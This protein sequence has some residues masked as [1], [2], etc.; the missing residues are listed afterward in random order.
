MLFNCGRGSEHLETLLLQEGVASFRPQATRFA[1]HTRDS[2]VLSALLERSGMAAPRTVYRLAV[3]QTVLEQ[4]V[5]WLGGF[6]LVVKQ[7]G[8]SLGAGVFLAESMPALRSLAEYLHAQ[9]QICILR[10]YIKPRH[11]GRILVLDDQV[12]AAMEYRIAPGDFRGPARSADGGVRFSGAGT[13]LD[14][15][16]SGR[17]FDFSAATNAAARKAA[18]IVGFG[19]TGVDVLVDDNSEPWILEVNPP[20]NFVASER[21]LAAPVSDLVVAALVRRAVAPG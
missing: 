4:D 9:N 7:V 20:S 15:S 5:A 6:P 19:F 10:R 21:D 18:A 12:I 1:V 17:A 8:A 3:D 11:L 14:A 16:I 2:T 13:A